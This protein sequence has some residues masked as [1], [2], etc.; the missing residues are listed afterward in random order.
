MIK[1]LPIVNVISL[2][3][4][5]LTNGSSPLRVVGEDYLIYVAKHSK[6]KKPSTDIINEVLAHYFLTLW[7]V[8]HPPACLIKIPIELL[9]AEYSKNHKPAYYKNLV[10]GSQF[11]INAIEVNTFNK[12][13]SRPEFKKFVSPQT[14]FEIALF[15]LWL[16]NIDRHVGNSNCLIEDTMKGRYIVPIDHC[17]IFEGLSLDDLSRLQEFTSSDDGSILSTTLATSIK[18]YFRFPKNWAVK[19]K[20]KFYLRIKDCEQNYKT[21]CKQIPKEWSFTLNCQREVARLLFNEPRNSSVF[22]EFLRLIS[23]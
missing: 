3:D 19:E 1:A 18:K 23:K 12:I 14:I 8:K 6:S 15:D 9:K 21:I 2:Q 7:G 16:Q 17:M 20:E 5:I 13:N 4:E 10:F 22:Q 11:V